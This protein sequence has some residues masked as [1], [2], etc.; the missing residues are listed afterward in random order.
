MT[1]ENIKGLQTQHIPWLTRILV[2]ALLDSLAEEREALKDI[3][4]PAID[5]FIQWDPVMTYTYADKKVELIADYL[6]GK[7]VDP[8]ST[9]YEFAYLRNREP[10]RVRVSRL[11]MNDLVINA[12]REGERSEGTVP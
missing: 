9:E 7:R 5:A 4:A 12:D 6:L 3:G 11:D 8:H 2:H 10:L 1:D